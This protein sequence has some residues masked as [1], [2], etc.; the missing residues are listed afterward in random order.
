MSDSSSPADPSPFQLLSRGNA[1]LLEGDV[2]KAAWALDCLLYLEPERGPRLWQRG[3]ACY[4]AGRFQE[5]LQQFESD[6]AENGSD[7]EE[8]IWHFLCSCKAYGFQEARRK[9]FLPL[10]AEAPPLAPP[11]PM[12]QV[13]SM[14]QGQLPPDDVISAS[15]GPDGSPLKSYNDTS[16]LPYANFYVGLYFE[17]RG[18]M[19]RA[20]KYHRAA[21]EAHSPDYMGKLMETHY[22]IFLQANSQILPKFCLGNTYRSVLAV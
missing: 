19:E 13:L 7:V 9:G 18:E 5:G 15:L 14:F 2:Q 12:L 22:R 17:A 3:L 16:A 10:A 8:V 20:R 21:A 1:S 4:Y 11:P 6:M